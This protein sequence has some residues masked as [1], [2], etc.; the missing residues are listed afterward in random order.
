MLA[1]MNLVKTIAPGSLRA[2]GLAFRGLGPNQLPIAARSQALLLA[3]TDCEALRVDRVNPD[4]VLVLRKGTDGYYLFVRPEYRRY[5]DIA[6]LRFGS[7]PAEYDVDH[8]LARGLAATLGYRYVLLA[9]VPRRINRL[10]GQYERKYAVAPG[11]APDICFADL[12][13]IDKALRFNSKTRRV[14]TSSSYFY[15]PQSAT[16]HGLTLKQRGL[17]NLALGFCE[18]PP[19]AFTRRLLRVATVAE[20]FGGAGQ[21]CTRHSGIFV[22]SFPP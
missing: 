11:S 12:R 3:A 5:R 4:D 1:M 20:A 19:Q 17:W 22:I 16:D 2:S 10:H 18:P 14:L 9:L 7:I 13:I 8:V 21:T 15:E 6:R